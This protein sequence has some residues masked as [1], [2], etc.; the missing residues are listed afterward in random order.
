MAIRIIGEAGVRLR[1]DGKGL[2]AEIR[3]IIGK[4]LAEAALTDDDR[5]GVSVTA[6]MRRQADEDSNSIRRSLTGL[7]R[8]ARSVAG[9]L[10]SALFTGTKLAL[11]G[12]AAVGAVAGVVSLTTGV[13]ALVG[14]LLQASGVLGLLPAV[15]AGVV[16][17]STALKLATQGMGDAFKAI[18]SGDAAAFEESLK[19]MAPAAQDFARAARD[20]KPAFDAMRL[21]VQQSLFEGL[22]GVV[23]P[24]ADTYLPIFGS[25]F[26]GIA[27]QTGAA[28]SEVANFL[29]ESEN[30]QKVGTFTSNLQEAWGNVTSAIKPAVSAI[31]DVVSTGS[32]F[33]PG[34]TS[35]LSTWAGSFAARIRE[36]AAN[37]ELAAFFQRAIDT[38][39]TLG[40]IG[41]NVFGA[42]R[43]VMDAARSSG[44]GLL[45]SIE[46]ITAKFEE[47]TGSFG[48]QVALSSFFES[49]RRAL[50][51]VLPVVLTLFEIIGTT[52]LPILADLAEIMGPVLRPLLEA[53]GRLLQAARPLIEALAQAL[54]QVLAAL[55]PVIDAF[56]EAITD[57]MPELGPMIQEIGRAFADL[58]K[59]LA[60]LAPVFIDLLKAVLPILPPFIDMIAELLPR[61]I[62][63]IK[64]SM[65]LIQAMAEAFIVALPIFA[66]IVGFL[67]DVFI[68][69]FG[70]VI[71]IISGL[72]GVV[73]W[74]VQGIYDIITSVFGAIGDF[75]SYIWNG[76]GDFF[77]DIWSRIGGIFSGGI[78]NMITKLGEFAS[79]VR[80]KAVAAANNL[81][82]AIGDGIKNTIQFFIDLPGRIAN[83]VA[84][85]GR[86]LWQAGKDLVMG[87]VNGIKAMVQRV[88]DSVTGMVNDAISAAKG[89][90]GVKSPSR[91]FKTIG[92]QLGQGLVLGIEGMTPAV[93][94][95]A[96]DMAAAATAGANGGIGLDGAG[97][98]GGA[99]NAAAGGAL[100]GVVVNQ[101]NVMRPGTDVN[102]FS[103]L[104][105]RRGFS[106]Y[107]TGGSTLPVARQGVQAGVNDQ[108]VSA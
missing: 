102:Q 73:T 57:A 94:N 2:D 62:E 23:Q 84:D 41:G 15:I 95:A 54:G 28:A 70:F 32:T 78:G 49:M 26:E 74:V 3:G 63:L 97:I 38:L 13:G 22:A 18:A 27:R 79:K 83:A 96:A 87:L 81:I 19:G 90:L 20:V 47:W 31:L 100:G 101:T 34:L 50:A 65:P 52:L 46:T 51:A 108:W 12:T 1:A 105:L 37:G 21:R 55:E 16:V 93:A 106:N 24:L 9:G 60:P 44:G 85:I 17:V 76:I 36:M 33:L 29:L 67:L 103:N 91:V 66:D 69:V 82:N 53:F 10:A 42:L 14:A 75:I 11:I 40:R 5:G 43:N 64:E 39:K 45:A 98:G 35:S 8:H 99:P 77:S 86:W 56:G 68:P 104:V 30:V 80:D 92:E 25:A 4:A 71:D 59:A 58:V 7:L 48:G 61:F 6:G 88:I 89:L 107:L 72:I